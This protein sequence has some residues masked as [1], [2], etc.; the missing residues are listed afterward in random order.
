[1]RSDCIIYI[2]GCG[3]IDPRDHGLGLK[4]GLKTRN[5]KYPDNRRPGSNCASESTNLPLPLP[6]PLCLSPPFLFPSPT[7][8]FPPFP[9]PSPPWSGPL[10]TS[11][12]VWGSAVSS[13]CGVRGR[14]LAAVAF[15]CI[16]CSQNASGC[17]ISGSLVS[18]A[19]RGKMKVNLFGI[20]RVQNGGPLKSAALFVRPS[21]TCLRPALY[22]GLEKVRGASLV[23]WFWPGSWEK[24]SG[25]QLPVTRSLLDIT[26][27]HV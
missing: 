5:G 21:R 10:K 6:L 12:G 14:V 13:P 20:F 23:S 4:I 11:K 3:L 18:I 17:S 2:R 8:P 9:S 19:M 16:V 24:C 15:C 22:L 26:Y 7:F 1:M 27:I 25:L